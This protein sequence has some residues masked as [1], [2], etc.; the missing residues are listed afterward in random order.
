MPW[1]AS[2]SVRPAWIAASLQCGAAGIPGCSKETPPP[3]RPV[4]EVTAITVEPRDIPYV[5]NFVAQTE[6]SRQVNIVARVS[7]YLDRIAYEEGVLVKAGQ[8]LFQIDPRPFQAQLD[9]ACKMRRETLR[10]NFPAAGSR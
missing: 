4:P 7:G 9:T 3:R 2:L 6:S 5:Q 1:N 8:V 10:F